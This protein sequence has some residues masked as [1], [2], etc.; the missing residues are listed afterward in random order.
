MRTG[1]I[2]QNGDSSFTIILLF[3]ASTSFITSQGHLPLPI[4]ATT[5]ERAQFRSVD[6][7]LATFNTPRNPSV[8]RH[9]QGFTTI[10]GVSQRNFLSRKRSLRALSP[11]HHLRKV[12][13]ILVGQCHLSS[14]SVSHSNMHHSGVAGRHTRRRMRHGAML[15]LS[16]C[17]KQSPNGAQRSRHRTRRAS[18]LG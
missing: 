8:P 10:L 17:R 5:S 9:R 18:I 1:T 11:S 13:H 4:I 7:T 16:H 6:R 3:Q 12:S 15:R 14:A 2:S